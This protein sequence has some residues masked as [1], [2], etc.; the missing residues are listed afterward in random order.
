MW[1]TL[2]ESTIKGGRGRASI[3][4]TV[5]A[6]IKW[7]EN[8]IERRRSRLITATRNNTDNTKKRKQPENKNEKKNNSMDILYD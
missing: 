1:K 2:K 8:Y 4:D 5:D 6:L 7:Q 3:E